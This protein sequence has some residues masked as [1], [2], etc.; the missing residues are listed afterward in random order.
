MVT[1]IFIEQK[2]LDNTADKFMDNQNPQPE[3]RTLL[4]R[5]NETENKLRFDVTKNSNNWKLSYGA[6]D[7]IRAVQ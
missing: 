3:E 5:S 4:I 6:G 7:A 1:G 2:H